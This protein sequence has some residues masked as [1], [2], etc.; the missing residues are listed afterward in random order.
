MN[1]IVAPNVE[2]II[3]RKCL[4]QSAVAEKAGYSKQQFNDMLRGRRVIR[5][6]DVL[7]IM[8]ALEVDA[9]ELF[10]VVEEGGER[11]E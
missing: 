4:K 5:D 10:K 8:L 1:S 7:K 2:E 9:N 11:G 6:I 3:T